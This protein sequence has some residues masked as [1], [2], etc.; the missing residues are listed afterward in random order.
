MAKIASITGASQGIGRGI[1][2]HLARAGYDIGFSY[3]SAQEQAESLTAQIEALGRRCRAYRADMCQSGAGPAFVKQAAEEL[4]GLN[5]LVNNAG[6]T[7]MQSILDLT[8]EVVDELINLDL[9]NSLFCM[10]TAA[11]IMIE[12]NIRGSIVNITSSRAERAYPED[13]VYGGVKAAIRRASQSAA[14]DLAPYG[15]RVNCVAPGAIAIRSKEY[16]A[17]L[18]WIPTDFWEE[19]GTRIPLERSGTPEDVA[20]AVAFLADEQS[21]YIT[22]ETIRV[23]G[24]LILPGMPEGRNSTSWGARKKG[25]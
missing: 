16:L 22:G 8:P 5:V 12:R 10:Q 3:C 19:L 6:R 7:R 20:N 17:K 11:K 4:D 15:I 13:A 21:D 25:E 18:K 1:A 9:K 14:L 2:L 23:D 24:G